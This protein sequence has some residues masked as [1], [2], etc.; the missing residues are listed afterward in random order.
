[1]GSLITLANKVNM[2]KANMN[3]KYPR[4][5]E[6]PFDSERKMMTTFH[7]NYIPGK[8]VSFTKG[9]P[10]IIMDRCKYISIDGQRVEFN[11]ILRKKVEEVNIYFAKDALRVLAL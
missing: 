4:I 8:I 5:R 2:D 3:K 11:N 9:A 10:D 7:K 1:E 6:I